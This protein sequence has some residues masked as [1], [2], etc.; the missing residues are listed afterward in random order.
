MSK[1]GG[2]DRN[3]KFPFERL[4]LFFALPTEKRIREKSWPSSFLF[5]WE[6]GTSPSPPPK[7]KS[8]VKKILGPN[9]QS[10]EKLLSLFC[11]VGTV[12]AELDTVRG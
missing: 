9:F 12:R 10:K 6:E 2:E 1:G 3:G 11:N 7:K 5:R 4:I 8:T